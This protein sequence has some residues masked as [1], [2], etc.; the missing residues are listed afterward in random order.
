LPAS[1]QARLTDNITLV[2]VPCFA[3]LIEDEPRANSGVWTTGVV[4]P[5]NPRSERLVFGVKTEQRNGTFGSGCAGPERELIAL[6]L[7]SALTRKR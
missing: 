6:K 7:S 1:G 5:G 4:K 3:E 2:Q